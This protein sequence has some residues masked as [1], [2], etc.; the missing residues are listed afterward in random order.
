MPRRTGLRLCRE[1][2][3]H[4]ERFAFTPLFTQALWGTTDMD[5]PPKV[6]TRPVFHRHFRCSLAPLA[7]ARGIMGEADLSN[8]RCTIRDC[9]RN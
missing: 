9:F 2:L 8:H 1:S 5:C 7:S 6:V 4:S 3:T